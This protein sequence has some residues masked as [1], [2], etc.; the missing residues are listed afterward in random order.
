MGGSELDHAAVVDVI[1]MLSSRMELSSNHAHSSSGLTTA[2]QNE[3]VQLRRE[4]RR[5]EQ[6]NEILRRA[7]A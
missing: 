4:K 6:A 1:M 7:T 2:E 5:L 3:L